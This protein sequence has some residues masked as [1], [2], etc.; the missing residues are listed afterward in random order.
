MTNEFK[1]LSKKLPNESVVEYYKRCRMVQEVRIKEL[2]DVIKM[3][4]GASW[5]GP[6]DCDNFARQK[7]NKVLGF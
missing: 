7:A 3:L 4:L 6:L 1:D 2:E 5:N